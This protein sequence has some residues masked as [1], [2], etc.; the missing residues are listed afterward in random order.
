MSTYAEMFTQYREY[1]ANYNYK[2]NAGRNL[3]LLMTYIY[4]I[5]LENELKQKHINKK[6]KVFLK[7]EGCR[8]LDS[9]IVN[10][11]HG[12]AYDR[13]LI[14]CTCIE[15]KGSKLNNKCKLLANEDKNIVLLYGRDET[16]K[17]PKKLVKR[18]EFHN[19]YDLLI[20]FE[21]EKMFFPESKNIKF[22]D[23][24]FSEV[25][26]TMKYNILLEPLSLQ[27]TKATN[28]CNI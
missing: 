16:V 22:L 9:E 10:I 6:Y 17:R 14:Q 4:T 19:I 18:I 11:E 25:L 13:K 8:I 12:M 27:N 23:Y 26:E 3:E 7:P 21:I 28:K 5:W 20:P 2:N 24:L 15:N 1:A